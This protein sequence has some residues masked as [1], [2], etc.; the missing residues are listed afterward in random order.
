MVKKEPNK[1]KASSI[2]SNTPQKFSQTF[3]ETRPAQLHPE[4]INK[5]SPEDV[6]NIVKSFSE[7]VHYNNETD[8]KSVELHYKTN[9]KII[10]GDY[11]LFGSLFIIVLAS[12]IFFEVI[13]INFALPLLVIITL[14]V[15]LGVQAMNLVISI[16]NTIIKLFIKK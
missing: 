16:L 14:S 8:R 11:L 3:K 9:Q 7:S 10:R 15:K 13:T 6:V 12:A 5:F 4:L 1:N 2:P